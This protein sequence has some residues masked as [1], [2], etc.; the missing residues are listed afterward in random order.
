M[1]WRFNAS[2][3]L[4]IADSFNHRLRKVDPSGNIAT[5]AGTGSA[6]YS[7]DFL[8]ALQSQ[9]HGPYGLAMDTQGNVYVN[10]LLNYMLRERLSGSST[11]TSQQTITFN[12]LSDVTFGVAPYAVSATS[13]SGLPVTLSSNSALVCSVSGSTITIIGGGTCSITASQ[14]GNA[15]YAAAAPVTQS[16]TV[17]LASQTITCNWPANPQIGAPFTLSCTSSSGLPVTIS[18]SPT[19]VCTVSGRHGHDYWR[20]NVLA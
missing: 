9:M 19:S 5:V 15:T 12:P 17:N 11:G 20:G 2:G 8:P 10:D 18:S 6:G 1:G 13:S 16:F 14:A 4:Y 3:N 7:G